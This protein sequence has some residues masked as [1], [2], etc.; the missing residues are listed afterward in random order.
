MLFGR[1]PLASCIRF[2]DAELAWALE[3]GLP[4][5]EADALLGGPY[6]DARMGDFERG[7]EMLQRSKAICRELG[8]AYGLP[9]PAWQGPSSRCW[10]ATW[11]RPS[12]SF[13]R[14]STS[15]PAWGRPTTSPSTR[16]GSRAS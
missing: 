5:V 4:A 13:A 11:T 6:I 16:C 15:R 1:T 8:I 9:R 2:L 10:P 14:R 12:G 3:H 7:R